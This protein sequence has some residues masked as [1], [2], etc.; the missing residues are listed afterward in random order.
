[1]LGHLRHPVVIV[2]EARASSI[3][4]ESILVIALRQG[5]SHLSGTYIIL[6]S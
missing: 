6:V 1:L 5:Q 3:L 4:A 2:G